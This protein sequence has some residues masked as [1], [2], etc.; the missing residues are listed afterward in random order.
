MAQQPPGHR[1]LIYVL[2][3]LVSVLLV[4]VLLWWRA[5]D[6]PQSAELAASIS[7]GPQ[8]QDFVVDAPQSLPLDAGTQRLPQSCEANTHDTYPISS[9]VRAVN[10]SASSAEVIAQ[11]S[12]DLPHW[13]G[14]SRTPY[15]RTDQAQERYHLIGVG[16]GAVGV[17]NVQRLQEPANPAAS[18]EGILTPNGFAPFGKVSFLSQQLAGQYQA[19][20]IAASL[21]SGRAVWLEQLVGGESRDANQYPWRIMT[22]QAQENAPVVEVASSLQLAGRQTS[23]APTSWRPPVTTGDLIAVEYLEPGTSGQA[24]SSRVAVFDPEK[25]GQKVHDFLGVCRLLLVKT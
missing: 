16:D 13:G 10:G 19:A 2:L 5:F 12:P 25:P 22:A 8:S 11:A 18:F 9:V 20:P 23:P 14:A 3:S 15:V 4:S 21:Q 7:E 1:T 17:A 6:I 24:W